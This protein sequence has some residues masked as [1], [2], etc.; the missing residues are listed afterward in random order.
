MKMLQDGG[1]GGY[2][3]SRP[4]TLIEDINVPDDSF[5]LLLSRAWR[6]RTQP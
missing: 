5:V 3:I 2:T 1:G 4:E 6:G